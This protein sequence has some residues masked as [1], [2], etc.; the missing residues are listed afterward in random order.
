MSFAVRG[1]LICESAWPERQGEFADKIN[2]MPKYVVSSTLEEPLEW[3]NSSL[4]QGDVA[5]EVGKLKEQDGR[6]ILVA[7]SATLVHSLIENDL[8]DELRLMVF[9]VMIGGGKRPFPESQQKKPFKLTD[10]QTFGS[11]V[12]VHSYEPA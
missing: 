10:T 1:G 3:N 4:I 11:G 9:T 2:S 7:G 12:A 5:A 8:V 6:P